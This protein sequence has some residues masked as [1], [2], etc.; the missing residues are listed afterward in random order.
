MAHKARP[1]LPKP[2]LFAAAFLVAIGGLIYELILG[3][4]ASFLFGDSIVSFSLAT[5]VTLFGMGI[6]SIVSTRVHTRSAYLFAWNEIALGLTGGLSVLLLFAAF[7]LTPYYWLVFVVLSLVIGILIGLEIPLMMRLFKSR[8]SKPTLNLLGRVLALDYLGALVASLLFPF[9]LLPHLGLMRTALAV[10]LINICVALYLLRRLGAGARATFF[11]VGVI[12]ILAITF[13]YA[14]VIEQAIDSAAYRDPVVYSTTSPYQKIV[15][16][17]FKQDTRLYL[18]NQLQFSS[19]DEARYHETLAHSAMSSVKNVRHI[20]VLGGGDGL[21]ARELLKYPEVR[22]ITV[23][24][25]DKR[26]TDLAKSNRIMVGLNDNSL[27]DARVSILNAD[28]FSHVRGSTASYDVILADLVDPSNERIAKLYSKEFYRATLDRLTPS[29][30]F[31]TQATS[32]YFTP[33]AF[34]SVART[35]A[36]ADES[37]RTVPLGINVP[38]FGEWGFVMSLPPSATLFGE[39]ALP[40]KLTWL[41][42]DTLAQSTTLPKPVA[43]SVST[44]LHPSIYTAYNADMAQ[45]RY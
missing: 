33:S 19:I 5:G 30:V 45:W 9:V 16:T 7:S 28:A 1:E 27:N 23:I 8:G 42:E 3:T 12:A 29:G 26:M 21:L 31:I 15:L 4:A 36:A 2:A 35:V 38:S 39:R 43:G 24:D 18:N 6:G 14:T 22:T 13:A 41:T 11:S 20:A 17:Q 34:G 44:L 10:A 40:P 37:R 32:T 25:L